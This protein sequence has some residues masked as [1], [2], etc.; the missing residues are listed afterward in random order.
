MST[1]P[2]HVDG[3]L[4]AAY[5][6]GDVDDAEAFSV[7]AHI[8]GCAQLPGRGRRRVVGPTRLETNWLEID[9]HAGRAAAR[10]RRRRC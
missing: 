6:R 2:W 5:A 10:V 4:L 1:A 9:R 8:V 7:E 3:A